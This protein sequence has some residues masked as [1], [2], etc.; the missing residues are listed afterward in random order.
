[1][2]ILSFIF[3]ELGCPECFKCKLKLGETFLKNKGLASCSLLTC[4]KCGYSKKVYASVSNDNSFDINVRT[5]YSTKACGQGYAGLEKLTAIMNL[6]KPVTANNYD[7]IVNR[8][9][10]VAKEVAN[11][12]IRDASEDLLSKSRDPNDDTVI[13]TAVNNCKVLFFIDRCHYGHIYG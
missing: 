3:S 13:D 12:T 5:V 4:E 8:L 1:M 9:K 6:P 10:F 2:E 7:K 11:E